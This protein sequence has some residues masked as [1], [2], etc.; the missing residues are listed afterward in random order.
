MPEPIQSATELMSR[1]HSTREA[2]SRLLSVIFAYAYDRLL[3]ELRGVLTREA[4]E[5][6][7]P[8]IDALVRVAPLEQTHEVFD[9][10][11]RAYYC[12]RHR[13]RVI[14]FGIIYGL[15]DIRQPPD[16]SYLIAGG[17]HGR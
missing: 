9:E 10:L 13:L 11:N 17:Q 2:R 14:N 15:R 4:L 8:C 16:G 3:R 12:A 5:A 7:S 1:I 6:L